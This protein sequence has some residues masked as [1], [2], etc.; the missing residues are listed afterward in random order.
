[1]SALK[2]LMLFLLL[3]L[4]AYA[5]K[6]ILLSGNIRDK[7]NGEYLIGSNIV[8]I[9]DQTYGSFTDEFGYYTLQ[10]P[11]G[12]YQIRFTYLGYQSENFNLYLSEDKQLDVQLKRQNFNLQE[13][14]LVALKKNDN[15]TS[16]D[17]GIFK[18]S[19]EETQAIPAFLGEKDILKTVQLSPGVKSVGEGCA[20]LFVRGGNNSQNLILM[21]DAPIYYADHLMGFF[22]A[23]NSDAVKDVQVYKGTAPA[24]FGGRISSVLDVRMKD[25]DYRNMGLSGGVGLIASRLTLEGPLVTDKGSFMISGRRTYADLLLGLSSDEMIRNNDLFFY[26]LNLKINYILSSNN[27][28]YL[29]YYK[30]SDV[31]SIQNKFGMNWGNEIANVRLFHRWNEKISSNTTLMRSK[32]NYKVDNISLSGY[33]LESVISDIS[34]KHEMLYYLNNK[35][36]LRFGWVGN[37]YN[38]I[39]GQFTVTPNSELNPVK[40]ENRNAREGSLYLNNHWRPNDKLL[41]DYGFR[42]TNYQIVGPGTFYKFSQDGNLEKEF[43]YKHNQIVSSYLHFEPRINLAYVLNDKNSFKISYTEY[44]QNLHLVSNPTTTAPIDIWLT[45]DNLIKP[46]IGNQLSAGYFLNFDE[47]KFQ[48]SSEIYYRWMENQIDLRNG[49][50]ISAN[51]L[52]EGELLFGKGRA[53]GMEILLKKKEGNLTGWIA[54]TLARSERQIDGI[55]ENNWY[56]VKQ[57]I[58]HDVSLVL[59]YNAFNWLVFSS[60]FTYKSG[61]AVT[62]PVGKYEI[63][64]Q[65]QYYYTDRN[66]YRMPAYHRLDMGATI[67][68][69]KKVMKESSLSFTIYNVYAKKNPYTI[70]FRPNESDPS[71][72]DLVM[73]YLYTILPSITYNFRF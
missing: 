65:T 21:D 67:F 25:G 28:I 16:A 64:G 42:L 4:P 5:Q 57:D 68:L 6:K 60:N 39:P 38:I 17:L 71:K 32:Y 35:Y 2:I 41:V 19:N 22:S 43:L 26:D 37:L 30:G 8:V 12:N 59:N 70:D 44:T 20:G 24:Q 72:T 1:M 27:R 15:I 62:F 45:S 18:L 49:A 10:I 66:G 36:L 29:S 7:S 23:F 3:T 14:N 69:K 46:E 50:D 11:E 51:Q 58:L 34:L 9:G 52:I 61:Y 48:F 31:V 40:L 63:D 55:N 33:S 47:D 53:Y 13:F 56:P 54:Y 73:T